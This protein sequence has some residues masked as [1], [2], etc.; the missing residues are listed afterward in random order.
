MGEIDLG[1]RAQL[2]GAGRNAIEDSAAG[3]VLNLT[4]VSFLDSAGITA[5]V[6]LSRQAQ[7]VGKQ[8]TVEAPSRR[9]QR[10]LAL[11][12]LQDAWVT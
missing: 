7:A 1:S 9:V 4:A 2:L 11:T 12:G 5:L 3:V 6:M 10:V 8:F